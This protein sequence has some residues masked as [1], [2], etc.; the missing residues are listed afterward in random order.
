MLSIAAA[1]GLA[2]AGEALAACGGGAKSGNNA[3]RA[4][5]APAASAAASPGAAGALPAGKINLNATLTAG[6]GSDVGSMDPQS[7]AGTGGGNWPNTSTHFPT[8]LTVD[9]NTS[10][11][12]GYAVDWSR[13][14][15]RTL[16][17]TRITG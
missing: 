6:I 4:P 17:R 13:S 5:G 14:R 9:P 12:K 16:R 2:F 7:L 15:Q 3:A 8:P 10:E 1:G 11:V